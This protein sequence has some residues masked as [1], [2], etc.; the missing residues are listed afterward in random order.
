[1]RG[2]S[3]AGALDLPNHR[4]DEYSLRAQMSIVTLF[5]VSRNL[6]PFA[7]RNCAFSEA[8][9]KIQQHNVTNKDPTRLKQRSGSPLPRH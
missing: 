6:R 3:A 5:T 8:L 9:L 7:N 4:D 1:M 2:V